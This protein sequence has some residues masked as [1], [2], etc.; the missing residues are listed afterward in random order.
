[1]TG[2]RP[3]S[4][5]ACRISIGLRP[6]RS[7]SAGARPVRSARA[8]RRSARG[9]SAT[10]RIRS[11]PAARSPTAAMAPGRRRA[12]V[13]GRTCPAR[14]ECAAA[15]LSCPLPLRLLRA[16]ASPGKG[17]GVTAIVSDCVS[18]TVRSSDSR[19]APTAHQAVGQRRLSRPADSRDGDGRVADPQL[20]AWSGKQAALVHEQSQCRAQQHQ[21]PVAVIGRIDI[22]DDQAS[23]AHHQAHPFRHGHST[24]PSGAT[25]SIRAGPSSSAKPIGQ[26]S[27]RDGHIRRG[28]APAGAD[29]SS[30]RAKS[31]R[32]VSPQRR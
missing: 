25:V 8:L 10:R 32:T 21:P 22:G 28:G 6:M 2:T 20:A 29:T 14:R 5:P 7:R 19:V 24:V 18:T 26:R 23:V 27:G 16:T 17:G 31:E 1:M 4:A 11:I 9:A 13:E 3:A 30:G 12:R 15:L